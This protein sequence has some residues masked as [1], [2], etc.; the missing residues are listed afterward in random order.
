[1]AFSCWHVV[2]FLEFSVG[3]RV[4]RI[5]LSQICSFCSQYQPLLP[6][7]VWTF[8]TRF[9]ASGC[10]KGHYLLHSCVLDSVIKQ[11]R[12]LTTCI[13]GSSYMATNLINFKHRSPRVL[14]IPR[15]LPSVSKLHLPDVSCKKLFTPSKAVFSF[16]FGCPN[17]K[18]RS[19]SNSVRTSKS[20]SS[21]QS[22]KHKV[23]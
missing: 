23:F 15:R 12:C 4:S 20:F 16:R 7:A 2:F 17:S 14:L 19:F 1:M 5:G 8:L 6:V 13:T 10:F 21:L 18:S 22:Y 3:V 9:P 11:N